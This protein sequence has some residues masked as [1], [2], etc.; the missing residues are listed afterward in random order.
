MNW[1]AALKTCSGIQ[2]DVSKW[3]KKKN[4]RKM[5]QCAGKNEIRREK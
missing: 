1:K 3:N 4:G 2:R 5:Q